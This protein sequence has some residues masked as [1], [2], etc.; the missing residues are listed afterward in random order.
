LFK[1]SD[2][3]D[4][5]LVK[6]EAMTGLRGDTEYYHLECLVDDEEKKFIVCLDDVSGLRKSA[7][8]HLFSEA[9]KYLCKEIII[10]F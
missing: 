3:F 8:M 6:L 9:E 4:H 1:L 7:V 5:K 2:G 10:F